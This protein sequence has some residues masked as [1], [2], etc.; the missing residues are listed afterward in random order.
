MPFKSAEGRRRLLNQECGDYPSEE[1]LGTRCCAHG[2]VKVFS[3]D[4]VFGF[5]PTANV[6]NLGEGCVDACG[7]G[8]RALSQAIRCPLELKGGG[9]APMAMYAS[10]IQYVMVPAVHA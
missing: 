2:R 4:D 6:E 7:G 3:N 10:R 8:R 9:D 5:R 1:K